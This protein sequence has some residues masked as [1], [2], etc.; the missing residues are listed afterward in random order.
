MVETQKAISLQHKLRF[1]H[2]YTEKFK[3]FEHT[4][5]ETRREKENKGKCDAK[6]KCVISVSGVSFNVIYCSSLGSIS[7]LLLYKCL[8]ERESLAGNCAVCHCVPFCY[9]HRLIVNEWQSEIFFLN[10][11]LGK[12]AR[13]RLPCLCMEIVCIEHGNYVQ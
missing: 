5:D 1:I 9:Y 11:S 13:R 3:R 10:F 12:K 6:N 8:V 2:T 4:D 7:M